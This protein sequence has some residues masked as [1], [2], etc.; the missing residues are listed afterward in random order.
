MITS[1]IA[2]EKFHVL[3][4]WKVLTAKKLHAAEITAAARGIDVERVLIRECG[5]QRHIILKALSEYYNCPPVEYD[6]RMPVPPEL[7]SGLDDERLS[8]SQ[9]FP[10]IKD[11]DTVVLA[12]N[13]PYDPKVLE[14]VRRFIKAEKYEFRVALAEDVQWFIQDFLHAKPGRL[15]GTERTGLAFWRNTMAHWRTR[16]ACYRNDLAQARTDLAFLRWGLGL[17]AIADALM[18]TRGYAD[19]LYI[20]RL[21]IAA[22]FSL[23]AFGLSGYIK[24]RRE[25]L[26]PPK[27]HTLVEV[28]SA[29]LTFLE[30]YHFIEG[31]EKTSSTKETMLARLGDFLAD[32]CTILY[33]SPAS[34]ER[35]HLAR[36]RN[37][38]AGHRTVAACYRTIYAR[39]RT[40]LAF[41]RTGISFLSVGIGLMHYFK[42]SLFSVLDSI[43][44][45]MGILM[46]VDGALW[47]LPVRKEQSEIPRCPVPEQ[48]V[49]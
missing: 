39:A 36:E 22:G 43:L 5:V 6:E 42:L 23:T 48:P 20:Y 17:I 8:L 7:L 49:K 19:V 25:R 18:R 12:T 2:S 24:I 46:L 4:D 13:N 1:D 9:W 30:N 40:G 16:L 15:I 11:G 26:S 47:Y 31:T 3:F 45:V 37:V 41:I 33:P 21:M 29:T 14:E 44:I 10:I 28:T 32:H 35:T 34:R 38:L 27:H